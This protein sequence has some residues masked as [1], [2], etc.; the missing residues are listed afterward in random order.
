[1]KTLN[2]TGTLV[3]DFE[4][5]HN[6]WLTIEQIGNLDKIFGGSQ[7]F[8]KILTSNDTYITTEYT[9]DEAKEY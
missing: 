1:M 9:Y 3:K 2:P 5:G 8:V 4:G 6:E 7:N